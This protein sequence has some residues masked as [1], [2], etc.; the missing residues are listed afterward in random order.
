MRAPSPH[1]LFH[2]CS[3][4]L[5]VARRVQP[6][7]GDPRSRRLADSQAVTFTTSDGVELAGRLFG[8][9]DATAGVVLAHMLP[10][11]QSSWFEFADRLGDLGYRALTFDFRGYCPG[12]VA[13]CSEGEKA[14]PGSGRTLRAAVGYLQGSGG[15]ARSG[16]SGRAWAARRRSWSRRRPGQG[17]RRGRDA[18]GARLDRRPRGRSG[19]APGHHGRQAVPGRQRRRRRGPVRPDVLRRERSRPSVWRS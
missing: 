13:G 16:S 11:D 8:P 4:S 7:R 9:E 2:R 14:S 17:D 12:G 5:L 18:L 19:C 15:Q 10:A 6:G 3:S 1:R